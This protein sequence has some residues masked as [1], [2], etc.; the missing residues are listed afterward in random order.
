MCQY[1]ASNCKLIIIICKLVFLFDNLSNL[2]DQSKKCANIFQMNKVA[3]N[4]CKLIS[5]GICKS[6]IC[7]LFL[8][9]F[10]SF[11]YMERF[12]AYSILMITYLQVLKPI[13]I[14]FTLIRKILTHFSNKSEEVGT[15]TICT[16]N[17]ANS[18]SAEPF[19]LFLAI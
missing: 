2:S 6:I 9:N 3:N 11:I 1:F 14:Y 12:W 5:I 7:N 16:Y 10:T 13:C 17:I 18:R 8:E 19:F 15:P 4:Y